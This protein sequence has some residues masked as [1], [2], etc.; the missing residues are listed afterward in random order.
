MTMPNFL[1]IGAAKS[2]TTA[3]CKYLGLHPQ[4][5]LPR[6]KESHFF[7][8]DR[9]RRPDFRGPGDDNLIRLA[10]TERSAYEA[11]FAGAGG[12]PVRGEG[13]VYYLYVPGT[14]ERIARELPNV[15]LIAMLRNPIQ[16]AL[17]A[18]QHLARER[19][20]TRSFAGALAEEERYV[21]EHY[22]PTW[23]FTRCGFYHEQLRRYLDVFDRHQ[24]GIYLYED[25][26][27]DPAVF[28]R[29]VLGF[30]GVDQTIPLDT[31][32]RVNQTVSLPRNQALH[33]A[34]LRWV[35]PTRAL[36]PARVRTWLFTRRPEAVPR[37]VARKLVERFRPEVRA[38]EE[39]LQRDLSSWLSAS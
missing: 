39:L 1:V 29:D 33:R 16:R 12:K 22:E 20:V 27:V 2:G 30:L 5:F 36:V 24:L 3:L 6:H 11:L 15:K 26:Q 10:V 35:R 23:H 8:W 21:A 14:A 37:N 9:D 18:Y 13:S 19:R 31:T 25:F 32:R 38:L 17:S 34:A 7:L 4:V 28:M